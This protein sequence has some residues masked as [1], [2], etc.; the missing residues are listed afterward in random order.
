MKAKRYTHDGVHFFCREGT[1]DKKTFDEVLV[2]RTY[3]RRYFQIDPKEKWIDL[4]GNVGAFT[5]RAASL[6]AKVDVYEPDPFNCK[7]IEKNL[8]VN[9][10]DANIHQ[11]AVVSSEAKKMKMYVGNNNQVWRNSLYKDWGNQ[12]FNVDCIHF[13][14]VL[15]DDIS[16]KMDIEGAEMSIIESMEIFPKRMVFEWSFDVDPDIDR[17]RDS[18]KKL[19]LKYQTVKAPKYREDYSV[20]PESWFPPCA[21]VYCYEDASFKEI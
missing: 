16:L 19:S 5:V 9:G 14:E 13:E 7:M 10:L 2:G 1:S 11:K 3:E 17:Y 12:A 4:G 21:N 18:V 6:G 20:W 8:L 15:T